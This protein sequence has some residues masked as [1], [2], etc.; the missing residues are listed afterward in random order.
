MPTVDCGFLDVPG[1]SPG[2]EL[3]I[4]YGPTLL[5]DVGF[6]P[7]YRHTSGAVPVA[8]MKAI[9]A[10]VDTGA[11]EC[12]IDALL[13]AQLNLPKVDKRAVAGVHGAHEVEIVLAQVHVPALTF[14]VYGQ[15]AAVDLS[16]GGQPH[17]VLIGRTFLR[18]VTMTYE[19]ITGMVRIV[20]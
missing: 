9:H 17:L 19:G 6:D 11:T 13:A 1:G 18:H 16:G 8:G 14:T 5:V 15:F 12:C 3:L 10:L 20:K 7:N 2:A 4:G